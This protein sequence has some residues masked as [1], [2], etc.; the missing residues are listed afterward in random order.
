MWYYF[1]VF[2]AAFL[3]DL[4]PFIGPPAWV[5]M[6]FVQMRYDLN[7]WMVIITGVL[8][9]ALGRYVLSLYIPFLSARYIKV[10]K[11]EDLHFIG[12][13]LDGK[14][15]KTRFF[16]LVYTLM[17]LPTTALFTAAGVARIK[18]MNVIPSF[19]VGKFISDMVMVFTG[20]YV[21]NNTA[22]IAKGL[23]SWESISGIIIG[24]II[25]GLFLFI[26]WRKLL[27]EKK[28]ELNFHVWK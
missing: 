4:V 24:L 20:D 18:A 6:V 3:V 25:I 21:A 19:L 23:F 26:D 16:I 27:Q 13:Q 8:G 10:Q 2:V 1:L 15:W 14:G 11:N 12:Q 17:P 28:L 9:S 5:V 22:S 7:I